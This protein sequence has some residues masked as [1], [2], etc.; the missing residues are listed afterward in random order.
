MSSENSTTYQG[1]DEIRIGDATITLCAR[2]SSDGTHTR[3]TWLDRAADIMGEV[4]K[5]TPEDAIAHAAKT[6]NA[7]ACRHGWPITIFCPACH[8]Q[9]R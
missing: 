7:P 4:S 9:E 5:R 1:G 2:K 3:W 6:L 8:D